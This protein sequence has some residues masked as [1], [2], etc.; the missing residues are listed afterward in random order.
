MYTH[1]LKFCPPENKA[2]YDKIE[3]TFDTNKDT[4]VQNSGSLR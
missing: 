3:N 4:T 2:L 1:L